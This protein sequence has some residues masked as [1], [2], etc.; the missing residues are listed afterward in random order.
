MI[1]NYILIAQRVNDNINRFRKT[2]F[3]VIDDAVSV[4][5]TGA[6]GSGDDSEAIERA[7]YKASR[8]GGIVYFPPGVIRAQNI[9]VYSN[10]RFVGQ[11]WNA[12]TVKLIDG[13][14]EP[15]FRY[16]TSGDCQMAGWAHMT[17]E[18]AGT[19][20]Q[21]GIDM[22]SAT[23]WQFSNN[24]GLR[25]TNFKKGF[26]G[27]QNDRRPSFSGCQFWGN[28]A[29]YYVINNHPHFNLCD[30]RDNNYGV[31][32]LTL[33]D[34]QIDQTVLVRNNYGIVPDDGGTISQA[35]ITNTSIFGNY[36]VG[37]R[38]DARV[39]FDGC[40]LVAGSGQD[41][42]SIGIEFK[43][44]GSHWNGGVVRG[45]GVTGFGDAAFVINVIGDV[46]ISDAYVN[47]D[48][49]V[50]TNDALTTFRRIQIQN[51]R[52]TI[53]GYFARLKITGTNGVQTTNITGNTI[54][55]PATGGLLTGSD[56]IIEVQT[57]S[58]TAGNSINDNIIHCLDAA[59]SAYA[60]QGDI[61]SAIVTGNI[62]RNTAGVNPTNSDINTVY[63][64]N[65]LPA[66]SQNVVLT[67]SFTWDPPS[68]NDGDKTSTTVTVNS[69]SV[70]DFV[71]VS[72][73]LSWQGVK[74]WG[75]V[76]A[77]N[78]VTVYLHNET[79]G[80]VNIGSGTVRVMVF[81]RY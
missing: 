22:S 30:I 51:N 70:G 45:E 16:K 61:R 34:M 13:A 79:G 9:S 12:T 58:T 33:Y 27:S 46:A 32:G 40:I 68:L 62:I 3:N 76:T 47:I 56:G 72:H 6:T 26:Y 15:L 37:A 14:T 4:E 39:S 20:Q 21:D 59:Y 66:R 44:Q 81:K 48:N 17:L 55:I 69:A 19:D 52:G 67:G 43:G 25:I 53:R 42:S 50:R 29:A 80:V 36:F 1:D 71:M 64:Q 28:D 24:E 49:F 31:T 7:A 38:V 5:D 57:A 11:G 63:A 73:Q 75:D 60:I 35:L 2:P 78:T 23:S 74:A 65:R 10:V 77:S 8:R 54:E 41:S 18:G